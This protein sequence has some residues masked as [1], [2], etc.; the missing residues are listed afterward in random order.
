MK[1]LAIGLMSGTSLDGIDIILAEISGVSLETKVKVLKEKTYPFKDSV[2]Q[3]IKDAMDDQLSSSK[4]ISSL[5]VELGYVFGEAILTFYKD[6]NIDFKD[7]SFIASH[8]QTIYHIPNDEDQLFRSSLQLGE[9]SIISELCKTTVISNF[10]L[11]DIA[12][13]GQGAPLVP[14]ADYILFSDLHISRAIHNIGGIA[15][16]TFIP[17]LATLD[18]VIAFD[19]GPGNMMI[20]KACQ[21]LYQKRYD[22]QGDISRSGKII[23]EMYDHMMKH[24]YYKLNYPKS[25]GREAFGDK[26]TLDLLNQFYMHEPKDIM[27]TLS[28][29]VIDSIV[30]SYKKIIKK[31]IDELI[32]CGGGA[33]NLFIKEE[34]AKKMKETKVSVLED[35]GYSSQY[36]EAL[37][38]IILGNQTLN[39]LPSN[40][41]SATGAKDYKILGQ[42]NYYR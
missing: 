20:D 5:N 9:G 35:Y 6:E 26:Y 8:G 13:G 28:M 12:S 11:A 10:R 32:L 14:Y 42:I 1:K 27:H 17:K 39:H 16:M 30:D 15:N 21:L 29:V 2:V 19:S 18:D 33:L 38:F 4:L 37:A 25:T 24:P 31:P 3:K 34:I 23:K 40:V 22:D 7:I 41:K 36:K